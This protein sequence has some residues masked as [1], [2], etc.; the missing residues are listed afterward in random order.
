MNNEILQLM[1]KRKSFKNVD[2]EKYNRTQ[3]KRSKLKS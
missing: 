3:N 2:F 1:K